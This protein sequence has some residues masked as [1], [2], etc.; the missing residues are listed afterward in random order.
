MD[1]FET[2]FNRQYQYPYLFINDE[3][4]TDEFKAAVR[5]STRA[6]VT[7]DLVPPELWETPKWINLTLVCFSPDKAT[8]WPPQQRQ[9][10]TCDHA[11]CQH[12]RLHG[13]QAGEKMKE[14]EAQGVLYGGVESYHKM[15]RYGHGS[16]FQRKP[17]CAVF[18]C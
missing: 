4:F 7:F 15:C 5:R 6:K 3:P 16:Y 1:S 13:M 18:G 2:R 9:H 14:L 8:S 10:Q 11:C 17:Y 12:M